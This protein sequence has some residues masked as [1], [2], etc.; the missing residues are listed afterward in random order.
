MNPVTRAIQ[1]LAATAVSGSPP[2]AAS[3][4]ACHAFSAMQCATGAFKY[5]PAP[6]ECHHCPLAVLQPTYRRTQ[7]E[8]RAKF[9]ILESC[10][11]VCDI[12]AHRSQAL[13]DSCHQNEIALERALAVCD[14]LQSPGMHSN[15]ASVLCSLSR[16]SQSDHLLYTLIVQPADSCL[17]SPYV[18]TGVYIRFRSAAISM[19]ARM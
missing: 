3:V 16:G 5:G 15:S 6:A 8:A 17:V 19:P 11:P 12:A 2:S 13:Q 18:Y 14:R 9:K 4:L 7:A 10:W 1:R